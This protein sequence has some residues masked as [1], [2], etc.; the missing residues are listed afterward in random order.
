MATSRLGNEIIVVNKNESYEEYF[1]E[2]GV[3]FVR[4]YPTVKL[5]YPTAEEIATLDLRGHVWKEG[6]YYWRVAGDEYKNSRYWWVL[7]WFNRKPTDAMVK[8]ND[9]IYVPRPLERVLTLFGV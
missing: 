4:Q 3:S 9:I 8:V 1:E 2:M 7:A 6:D 5:R